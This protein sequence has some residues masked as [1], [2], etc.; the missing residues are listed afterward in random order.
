MGN[1]KTLPGFIAVVFL[2]AV[3][4]EQVVAKVPPT[5]LIQTQFYVTK[6]QMHSSPNILTSSDKF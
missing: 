3:R 1:G 6:R 4:G 5:S 2:P